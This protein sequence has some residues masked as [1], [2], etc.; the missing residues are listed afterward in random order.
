MATFE[1]KILRKIYEVIKEKGW[2]MRHNYE[3]KQLYKG[4]KSV[5]HFIIQHLKWTKHMERLDDHR[6]LKR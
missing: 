3:L 5:D 1:R 2:R 6:L 4:R